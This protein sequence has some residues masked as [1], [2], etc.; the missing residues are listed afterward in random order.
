MVKEVA[1]ERGGR[2][3]YRRRAAGLCFSPDALRSEV[4]PVIARSDEVVGIGDG[5]YVLAGDGRG[6]VLR[7]R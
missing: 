6:A 3:L 5:G 1:E 2:S 7:L 4:L